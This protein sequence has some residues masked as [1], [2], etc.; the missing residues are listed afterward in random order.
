M[1]IVSYMN[2]GSSG[3]T[4]LARAYDPTSYTS[5]TRQVLPAMYNANSR[6]VFTSDG[7]TAYITATV[8]LLG[9]CYKNLNLVPHLIQ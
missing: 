6:A 1:I 2:A 5:Y 4:T 7:L 9:G 8:Q 3:F